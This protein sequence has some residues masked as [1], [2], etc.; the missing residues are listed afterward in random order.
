MPEALAAVTVP[1]LSKAGRS[2]EMPSIVTPCLMY[3]SC[4]PRVALAALDGDCATISSLNLPA[5]CAASALFC[6][7]RRIRPAHRAGAATAWRRSRPC[8]PSDNCERHRSARH[9]SWC[10][11]SWRRPFSRHRADAWHVRR[12]RHR[13]LTAGHND[14]G[15]AGMI[16]CIP[17]ATARRP[18]P[19]SWL[20]PQAVASCGM[21]AAIAAWRPG[22]GPSPA[23]EDLAHD[24]FVTSAG[25]TPARSAPSAND[26]THDDIPVM[27]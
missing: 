20:R 18:E 15:I 9:T 13:F 25:S 6:C 27:F 1:S 16:C 19:H 5:F 11:P 7:R 10:R 23:A 22:S 17:S 21:P 26:R 3:S 8:C 24:H 4:R 12:Q 2:L 14:I